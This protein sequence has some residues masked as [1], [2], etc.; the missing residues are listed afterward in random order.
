MVLPVTETLFRVTLL[1]PVELDNTFQEKVGV[2][3]WEF[4]VEEFPI[5]STDP[6]PPTGGSGKIG[7]GVA[8]LCVAAVG[9]G[10]I[11]WKR[12]KDNDEK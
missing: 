6:E 3:T 1:V 7:W 8:I 9:I 2:L 10:L 12:R 5:E 11:L 4:K